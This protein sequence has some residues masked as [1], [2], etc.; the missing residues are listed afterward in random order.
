MLFKSGDIVELNISEFAR[1][2]DPNFAEAVV[3]RI[4]EVKDVGK[5]ISGN[6]HERKVLLKPYK[7]NL[8]KTIANSPVVK[9]DKFANLLE[10]DR[11]Y[12]KTANPVLAAKYRK[13]LL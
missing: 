11:A 1:A 8:S 5:T 4:F 13:G 10:I 6:P 9:H 12:L 7:A 2:V 3:H